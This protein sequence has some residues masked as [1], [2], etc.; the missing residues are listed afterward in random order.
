MGHSLNDSIT[1]EVYTH[2]TQER[3]TPRSLNY[4]GLIF[5][6]GNMGGFSIFKQKNKQQ[7]FKNP[8]F[9]LAGVHKFGAFWIFDLYVRTPALLTLSVVPLI[10]IP[11]I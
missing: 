3:L 1:D 2:T 4:G 11:I 9:M 5:L 7:V 6:G 10:I 8:L